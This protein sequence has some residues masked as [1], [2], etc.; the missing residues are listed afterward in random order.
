MSRLFQDISGLKFNRLTVI[1]LHSKE[2]RTMWICLCDCGKKTITESYS[3]KNGKIKSCGCYAREMIGKM[4]SSSNYNRY[5]NKELIIQEGEQWKQ[6]NGFGGIYYIS[7][8]GQ[9]QSLHPC[10][11]LPKILKLHKYNSGYLMAP[12]KCDSK[13]YLKTVHRLVAGAFIPNPENKPCVNHIDGNKLNNRVENLEWCTHKENMRH[14]FNTGL[15]KIRVGEE[16]HRSKIT[17]SEVRE[18][19]LSKLPYK[20]LARKYNLNPTT[21]KHICTGKLW[22]HSFYLDS[23]EI[24]RLRELL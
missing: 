18:I 8:T 15:Y 13:S 3:L 1:S 14:G 22:A 21:I 2:K 12:L 19:R 20:Q 6:I 24:K 11:P 16:N 5:P 23:N 9:V 17:E 7:N 10:R 4:N